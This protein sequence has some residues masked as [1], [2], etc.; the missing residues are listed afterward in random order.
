MKDLHV[1]VNEYLKG[2]NYAVAELYGRFKNRLLLLAYNYCQ[3]KEMSRDIVQDVFE[4]LLL[5][6]LEKRIQYFGKIG[7]NIEAYLCVI[8]K[9]KCIDSQ[10]ITNSREK[11]LYNIRYPFEA[12]IKNTSMERFCMDGLKEMLTNLQPREQQIIQLHI[13]GYKNE[14]IASRLNITYNTVKNNIYEAK[15]KLKTLWNLF[16]C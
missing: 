1:L 4:K 11:I 12:S 2:D 14:E 6:P 9:N 3:D 10:R 8:V 16:M 5:L 13:D 7:A 15:K